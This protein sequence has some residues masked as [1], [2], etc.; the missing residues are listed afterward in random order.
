MLDRPILVSD[1]REVKV[2]KSGRRKLPTVRTNNYK[3]TDRTEEMEMSRFPT[4]MST[5]KFRRDT[6]R[7]FDLVVATM[8]E[9]RLEVRR[10][11]KG[12]SQGPGVN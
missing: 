9:L 11:Q 7:L 6:V 2:V 5:H 10:V 12:R 4:K 1:F 8:A 3:A